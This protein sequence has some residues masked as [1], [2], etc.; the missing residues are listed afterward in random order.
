M[1]PVPLAVE[2]AVTDRLHVPGPAP[3]H[4]CPIEDVRDHVESPDCWCR[5]ERDEVVPSL[6]IHR[7][8]ED[9]ALAGIEEPLA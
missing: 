5:P 9:R 3:V 6:W 7:S 2:Q 8:A 1:V 4:V